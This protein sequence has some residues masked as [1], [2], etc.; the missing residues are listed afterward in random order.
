MVGIACRADLVVY[1]CAWMASSSSSQRGEARAP[2]LSDQL[3]AFY[4]LVD[5]QVIAGALCRHASSIE[6]SASAATQAEALFGGDS[7][8]VAHL[9]TAEN[10]SLISLAAE[11]SGA[12]CEELHLRSWGVLVS[13][14]PLLLR[15][16][17]ASTLLSGTMKEEELDFAAHTLAVLKKAKNKPAL[18]PAVLRVVASTI[19]YNTLLAAMYR[20]L[21][22]LRR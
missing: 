5:K 20:S 10:F 17:E 16:V 4:K 18:S 22:L 6:L 2:P 15:R 9:R 11:A 8:V 19:G 7:L 3:A 1:T 21:D 13:L 12:E 14:I